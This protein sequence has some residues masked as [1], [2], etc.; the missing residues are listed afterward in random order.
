MRTES[1]RV[2][3]LAVAL[4]VLLAVSQALRYASDVL[5]HPWALADPPLLAYWRGEFTD[6][7]GARLAIVVDLERDDVEECHNCPQIKGRAATCDA[8]GQIRRYRVSGS[9]KDRHATDLTLGTIV[10]PQPPP[11][12]LELNA[13]RGAWDGGDRLAMHARFFWR[14]GIAAIS[15][16]DDPATQPVPVQLQ[17]SDAASFDA[18]CTMRR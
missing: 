12:G 17:R 14:K 2:L 3:L 11:D 6:G 13:L 18:V 10:D 9:P 1:K 16:T 5:F 4:G 7:T 15:A 8:R